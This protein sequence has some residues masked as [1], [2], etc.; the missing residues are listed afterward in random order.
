MYCNYFECKNAVYNKHSCRYC[1]ID[2]KAKTDI[3]CYACVQRDS[4]NMCDM[5]VCSDCIEKAFAR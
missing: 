2:N 5:C 1:T 3:E 4:G